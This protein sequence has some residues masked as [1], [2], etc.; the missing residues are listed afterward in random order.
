MK[1]PYTSCVGNDR[2]FYVNGPG[3]G[4]G[5][6]SGTLWP[7]LRNTEEATNKKCATFA[8]IGYEQGYLQAQKDMRKAFGIKA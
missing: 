5:Y 1:K 2:K 3:D 7:E 6:Y 4:C 8:N